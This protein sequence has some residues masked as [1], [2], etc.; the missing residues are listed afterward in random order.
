[1][2]DVPQ[3]PPPHD[4]PWDPREPGAAGEP[5]YEPYSPPPPGWGPPPPGYA[6]PPYGYGPPPA[7]GWSDKTKTTAGLLQVLLPL[8]GV[9]GV[10]RLYAGHVGI[11]LTQ[12]IGVLVAFCASTVLVGIPFLIGLWLWS[13]IDGILMLTGQ[14]RDG[15]GRLLR[16]S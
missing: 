5:A 10:G 12:L 4:R 15:E 13:F 9:C 16:P 8:V 11:G 2:D 3:D 6:P 7:G 14:P 1:M